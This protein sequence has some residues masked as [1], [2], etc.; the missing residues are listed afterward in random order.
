MFD[1]KWS[2]GFVAVSFREYEYDLFSDFYGSVYII[3]SFFWC[4]TWPRIAG[5]IPAD[6]QVIQC[7]IVQTSSTACRERPFWLSQSR[8]QKLAPRHFKKQIGRANEGYTPKNHRMGLG[9]DFSSIPVGFLIFKWSS[10][11]FFGCVCQQRRRRRYSWIIRRITWE[12]VC[13][14]QLNAEVL[15]WSIRTIQEHTPLLSM[16]GWSIV[17]DLGF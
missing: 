10:R 5:E 7:G 12:C 2:R 4:K 15:S 17:S 13:F 14:S 16:P 11:Q 1:S 3:Y 8:N 6:L 9:V